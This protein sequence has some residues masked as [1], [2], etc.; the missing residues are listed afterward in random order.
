MLGDEL[1]GQTID[2]VA[3]AAK[4]AWRSMLQRVDVVDAGPQVH[5]TWHRLNVFYTSLYRALL[6]PRRL[7]ENTPQGV[8][9][10]SPYDGRVHEGVGVT[11]N[12]FWDTFR[13]VYPLLTLAYPKELGELISGWLNAFRTGGWLPKWASPGYRVGMVGT[14]ADVTIAD[15]IV[16]DISGFDRSLAWEAIKK[17]AYSSPPDEKDTSKG[18]FGLRVYRNTGYIPIDR[19]IGESCSR[20]LDFAFADAASSEVAKRL[21]HKGESDDLR[22]RSETGLRA[23]FHNGLMGRRMGS[24]GFKEEAAETW[25]DCFCEGSAWHHSFPPFNLE[26]LIQLHG[27]KQ[28]LL[29]KLHELFNT[30]ST[31]QAGSYK[32][33]IH[34][35]REMRMVGMGQYAHNDQPSHHLPYL[36]AQLG[37]PQTTA[38]IVRRVMARCYSEEG[39]LGY[40]DNGEMGAWYVLSALG[41][42]ATALGVSENYV[43]GA[44]PLFPRIWLK[45]LN[46][47]I[48]APQAAEKEPVAY[49]VFWDAEL[50]DAS[51]DSSIPYSKLRKGG[52]LRFTSSSETEQNA[53]SRAVTVLPG[54]ANP[55][56]MNGETVPPHS[57][58]NLAA[59]YKP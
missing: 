40:E 14:Y 21:D 18:K 3:N 56:A 51:S 9:H 32:V 20:T 36:F 7:D 42:Y 37:E 29:R 30:T 8:Q 54:D 52:T 2:S 47:F 43:I 44:V 49:R 10:W 33:V 31:L 48:E 15:A 28:Q 24:G 13:T 12:G 27:G 58:R 57:L 17:D 26:I 22:R 53:G 46:V 35:M 25:G 4:L 50:L 34:E 55:E 23:L 11:D 5:E 1:S 59:E 38:R 6:F 16:K 41:L 19:Q 39:F 45:D